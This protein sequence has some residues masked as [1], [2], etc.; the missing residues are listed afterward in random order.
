[1][2]EGFKALG[3]SFAGFEVDLDDLEH[4]FLPVKWE[5]VSNLSKESPRRS[6][7]FVLEQNPLG[8]RLDG[9]EQEFL[10]A[11]ACRIGHERPEVSKERSDQN[12]HG[13]PFPEHVL[14]ALCR[15]NQGLKVAH[16]E[17][18]LTRSPD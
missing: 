1:M 14:P 17:E 12:V 5:E 13:H 6:C 7:R 15:L 11:P 18:D 8:Q 10:I 2:T 16:S 3:K 9:F 4:P